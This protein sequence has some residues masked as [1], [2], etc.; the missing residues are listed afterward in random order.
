MEM[1]LAY[2]IISNSKRYKF[3]LSH[4]PNKKHTDVYKFVN[5][6]NGIL[7]TIYIVNQSIY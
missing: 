5:A 7:K 6:E 1:V 2:A 3:T 4:V